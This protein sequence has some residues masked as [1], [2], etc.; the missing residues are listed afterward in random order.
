MKKWRKEAGCYSHSPI[1]NLLMIE[2]NHI[3]AFNTNGVYMS[4][5]AKNRADKKEYLKLFKRY[6]PC[7]SQEAENF[8]DKIIEKHQKTIEDSEVIIRELEKYK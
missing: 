8:I 1:I 4:V 3:V 5:N 6:V 7:P 2:D